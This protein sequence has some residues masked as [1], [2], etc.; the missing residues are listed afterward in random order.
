MMTDK[1]KDRLTIKGLQV[2]TT[3]G[4]HA[5]E[6]RIK[7]ALVLD[8]SI[9]MDFSAC[10]DDLSQTLDYDSLCQKITHFL[11]TTSF[12]LI[13]TVANQVAELIKKE[14]NPSEVSVTVGKPHAIKNAQNIQVSVT[15]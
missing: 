4:V 15:R 2:P 7:Q 12:Q 3:I 13:E 11:E 8:I 9:P 14:F 10:Q 1:Q 5:W 6:Q